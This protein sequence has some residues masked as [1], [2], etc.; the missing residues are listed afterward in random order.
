MERRT[1]PKVGENRIY[2]IK[3]KSNKKEGKKCVFIQAKFHL[4]DQIAQDDW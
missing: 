2:R 1:S 4:L 3:T